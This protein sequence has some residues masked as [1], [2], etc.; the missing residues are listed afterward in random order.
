M[1]AVD[2]NVLVRLLVGD[3]ASQHAR[4]ARLFDEH[5][6]EAG[7]LW[8][9]QVVLVELAWVLARTYGRPREEIARAVRALSAN[10]TVA[11]EGAEAV[12]QAVGL[13][14]RGRADFADCLL[15]ARAHAAG[16]SRVVT[17]DRAM[18]GLPGVLVW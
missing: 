13:Y 18:R 17:F 6:D 1:I 9:S 7:A 11:L 10:S 8:V 4:A 14:E 5:A 16:C 15:C 2:T 3:D 12:E